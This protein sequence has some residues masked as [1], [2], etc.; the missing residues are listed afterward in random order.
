MDYDDILKLDN[1]EEQIKLLDK[2]NGNDFN[3]ISFAKTMLEGLENDQYSKKQVI[4][5]IK[6]F[7]MWI[8]DYKKLLKNWRFK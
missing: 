2:L 7:L 6:V 1:L 4:Y 8:N 5:F 3:E